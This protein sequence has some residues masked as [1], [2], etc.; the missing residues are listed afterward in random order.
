M[1]PGASW[2]API[3]V[4][5]FAVSSQDVLLE[6]SPVAEC[7]ELPLSVAE[8]LGVPPVPPVP[9]PEECHPSLLSPERTDLLA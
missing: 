8:W 7:Y 4:E 9:P 6:I 2:T 1:I 5:T 3:L